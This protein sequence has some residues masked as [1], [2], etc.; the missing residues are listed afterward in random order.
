ML[1]LAQIGE[2]MFRGSTGVMF[3]N[4]HTLPSAN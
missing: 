4:T 3:L 2:P 1:E